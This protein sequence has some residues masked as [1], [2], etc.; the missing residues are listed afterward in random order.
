MRIISSA[1]LPYC[2]EDHH[3]SPSL[4]L[5][6]I[7][8]L[9]FMSVHSLVVHCIITDHHSPPFHPDGHPKGTCFSR[10]PEIS[11]SPQAHDF[12]VICTSSKNFIISI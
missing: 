2:S 8:Y 12:T 6:M 4:A 9:Y 11:P 3:F 5:Y 7:L 1:F 10:L